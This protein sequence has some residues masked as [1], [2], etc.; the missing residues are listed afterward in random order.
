MLL[1]IAFSVQV[2]C[3]AFSTRI[4]ACYLPPRNAYIQLGSM[5]SLWRDMI[6]SQA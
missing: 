2:L 4:G 1:S 3:S 6:L 5:P